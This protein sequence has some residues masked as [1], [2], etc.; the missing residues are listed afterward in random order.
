MTVH[1]AASI[2]AAITVAVTLFDAASAAEWLIA[3]EPST[4]RRSSA[5]LLPGVPFSDS[6]ST[7]HASD[8]ERD[9]EHGGQ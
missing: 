3:R 6:P 8:Q 4:A 2:S 1:A 5:G 7:S 9:N